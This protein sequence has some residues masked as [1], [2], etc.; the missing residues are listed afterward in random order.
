MTYFILKSL[1]SCRD[2]KP[3][4]PNTDKLMNSALNIT[5]QEANEATEKYVASQS[6]LEKLRID[7]NILKEDFQKVQ[8]EYEMQLESSRSAVDAMTDATIKRADMESQYDGVLEELIQVKIK[9]AALGE[10]L[11]YEKAKAVNLKQKL[12]KY[13]ERIAT[14]EVQLTTRIF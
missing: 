10:T 6:Q 13:A 11:D 3:S 4:F 14:L 9:Y 2:L 7:Y 5:R 8:T 1:L 12:L